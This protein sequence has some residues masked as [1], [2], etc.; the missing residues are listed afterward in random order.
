MS[1]S[2][3]PWPTLPTDEAAEDFVAKADL[4]RYD[5]SAAQ[6]ASYEFEDKSERVNLRIPARQLDDIKAEAARRGIKYQRLMRELMERGLQT[7][8]R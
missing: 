7:L 2:N 3:K 8:P 5:W 1:R 6:P 4:S